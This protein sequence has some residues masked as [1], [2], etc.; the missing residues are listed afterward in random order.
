MSGIKSKTAY[1]F[2][3][4]LGLGFALRLFTLFVEFILN[5]LLG[6]KDLLNIL[7]YWALYGIGA[8]AFAF[9]VRKIKGNWTL[10]DLGF[11]LHRGWKKDIWNGFVIASLMYVVTIPLEMIL[12]PSMTK[13]ATDSM[14]SFLK[15]PLLILIP[16]AGVLSLV[17]GF[18]TGAFHEEIWYRGYL[19]GLFSRELAPAAGFFFSLFVFSLGH[20]FSHPEWSLLNVLNTV[21]HAIF[22]CLAYNATG[23]LVVPMV[24]H[25][26]ANFAVPT[27]AIP[28]YAKGH[29]L[30][31]Y[32]ALI[33]LWL[34]LL[35]ICYLGKKELNELKWKTK[36]LFQKSG[37]QMSLLGILL[38]AFSLFF[39]WGQGLLRD[40]L[41]KTA[42]FIGL[43][44]FA[45]LAL[46]ISF[47]RKDQ[48]SVK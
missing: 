1:L 35:V 5:D 47:L 43:T 45:L 12:L 2:L 33:F 20:Y 17:F 13:L 41:P 30:A 34:I 8:A 37:W 18:I 21:P 31:A 48:A 32:V 42:Y 28:F 16:A 24:V 10:K 29:H 6:L 3:E 22:F 11:T 23:S 36:E 19:Q 27:F 7:F 44:V 39:R 14:G 25:T 4:Y 15:V 40:K 9:C 46:G 38:A 26:F